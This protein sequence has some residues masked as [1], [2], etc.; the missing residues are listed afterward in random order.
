MTKSAFIAF[1]A[2]SLLLLSG[3]TGRATTLWDVDEFL[4][5]LSDGTAPYTHWFNIK[6]MYDPA[7]VRVTAAYAWFSVKD[8]WWKDSKEKVAVDLNNRTFLS[9]SN[10]SLNLLGGKI[11]SDALLTLATTGTLKYTIRS[12]E[13]D[14]LASAAK[15]EIET[16]PRVPDGGATLMLLGVA[17]AAIEPLRRGLARRNTHPKTT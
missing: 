10:V 3:V 12:T 15:L 13:G 7:S 8:D 17:L 2:S 6:G 14:F 11:S 9:P 4:N 5:Y 16:R 1:V